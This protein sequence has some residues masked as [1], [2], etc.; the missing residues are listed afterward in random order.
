MKIWKIPVFLIMIL[1]EI[2]FILVPLSQGVFPAWLSS[3]AI[4]VDMVAVLILFT[5]VAMA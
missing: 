1:A 3:N 5:A 2:I 4:I